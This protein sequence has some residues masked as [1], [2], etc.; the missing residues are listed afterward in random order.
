MRWWAE[1][2]LRRRAPGATTPPGAASPAPVAQR[3]Q[4]AGEAGTVER[5]VAPRDESVMRKISYTC[6]PAPMLFRCGL[7]LFLEFDQLISDSD[8]TLMSMVLYSSGT[9]ESTNV[10]SFRN[11]AFSQTY[12]FCQAAT[13]HDPIHHSALRAWGLRFRDI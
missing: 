3:R 9:L 2:R 12:V 10:K 7:W 5:A 11:E 1:R 6:E 13:F 8:G 4:R